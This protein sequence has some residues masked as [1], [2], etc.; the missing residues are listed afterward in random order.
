MLFLGNNT[1]EEV[2]G[3]VVSALGVW[4]RKISNIG[5]ASD[6][7]PKIYYFE[8]L[9]ASD[10]ML[11]RWFRLYLQSFAPTNPHW[12]WPVLLVGKSIRKACAPAVGGTLIGWWWHFSLGICSEFFH[13]YYL[14]VGYRW[15]NQRPIVTVLSLTNCFC[16]SVLVAINDHRR[17][18][19]TV[20]GDWWI[21]R[22]SEG[23]IS[24]SDLV[25]SGVN[26]DSRTVSQWKRPSKVECNWA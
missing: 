6:G 25:C 8:L 7:W 23:P 24:Y 5:R 18:I 19:A 2:G 3:F 15:L 4:S 26:F 1:L 20:V 21:C 14:F 12:A 16:R 17:L 11:S 10:G 13:I 9:C 22:K